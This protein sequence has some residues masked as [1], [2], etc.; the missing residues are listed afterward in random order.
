MKH[1]F[2]IATAILV[3]ISF[4]SC[5]GSRADSSPTSAADLNA[6]AQKQAEHIFS[7]IYARCGD[8][9]YRAGTPGSIPVSSIKVQARSNRIDDEERFFGYEWKGMI[10]ITDQS[11]SGEAFEI[12]WRGGKWFLRVRD[13]HDREDVPIDV[14]QSVR[15]QCP[16]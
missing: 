10:G 5:N 9:Y 1:G 8:L 11:G 12:F 3:T 13:S 7:L 4:P 2:L 6:D 16:K 15:P 14:L